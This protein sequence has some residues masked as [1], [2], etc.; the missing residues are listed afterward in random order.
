LAKTI[1]DAMWKRVIT[2]ARTPTVT[3][4]W[5][6]CGV[7]GSHEVILPPVSLTNFASSK[8]NRCPQERQHCHI[9]I[10]S[11]Q[12]QRYYHHRRLPPLCSSLL[13]LGTA[14][15]FALTSSHN[16][17]QHQQQHFRSKSTAKDSSERIRKSAWSKKGKKRNNQHSSGA[18]PG[19]PKHKHGKP[20]KIH[21]MAAGMGI[22]LEECS[23]ELIKGC[24]DV[25]GIELNKRQGLKPWIM[26]LLI[27]RHDRG[28][29]NI[30]ELNTDS[31]Y[32]DGGRNSDI[33]SN[34]IIATAID[35]RQ[36]LTPQPN[37]IDSYIARHSENKAGNETSREKIR[38][39]LRH[40]KLALLAKEARR[41][42]IDRE[43]PFQE[44][45]ALK[46][47]AQVRQMSK[48]H[49]SVFLS[50][51][52][53][54]F[55]RSERNKSAKPKRQIKEGASTATTREHDDFLH[56]RFHPP[57]LKTASY[58]KAKLR[59]KRDR[60][61][62]NQKTDKNHQKATKNR[63]RNTPLELQLKLRAMGQRN[64]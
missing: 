8:Y 14:F 15:A 26:A 39:I 46:N 18:T 16:F 54:A 56:R 30:D 57:S 34:A 58:K 41:V 40:E 19:T 27:H 52:S 36:V 49:P 37:K 9:G 43:I 45:T 24:S 35:L 23:R 33:E 4:S 50:L 51:F 3:A 21:E 10:H 7:F 1:V 6:S 31:I 20:P 47:E 22:K 32:Y 29:R 5:N 42:L 44:L 11:R 28:I 60:D 2:K 48:Q 61:A 59:E 17:P 13:D 64:R 62:R 12:V 38:E 55:C 63:H 25:R 53:R